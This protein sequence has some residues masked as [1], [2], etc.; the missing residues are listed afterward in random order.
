M[1][2]TSSMFAWKYPATFGN[3]RTSN[4]CYSDEKQYFDWTMVQFELFYANLNRLQA[5]VILMK[6]DALTVHS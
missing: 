6:I 5:L 2:E 4:C 1:V 3:L